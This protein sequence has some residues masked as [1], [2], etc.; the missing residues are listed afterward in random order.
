MDQAKKSKVEG[1]Q[2]AARRCMRI[3]DWDRLISIK[4]Q[5]PGYGV[6]LKKMFPENC[7]TKNHILVGE[8]SKESQNLGS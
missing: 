6:S 5:K 7:A 2:E 4:E 1:I 8:M 3:V